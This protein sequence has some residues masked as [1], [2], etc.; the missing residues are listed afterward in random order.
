MSKRT[1]LHVV[2]PLMTALLSAGVV[3]A[4]SAA[5][6]PGSAAA[7]TPT[8]AGVH[9]APSLPSSADVVRGRF[10]APVALD[11]GVL[12][13]APAPAGDRPLVSSAKAGRKIWASPVL[14]SRQRGPL[15]YGLV[16]IS[17][18][19][20]GVPRVT[21][22]LA[23]VGFARSS[24]MANC[25]NEAPGS[26]ATPGLSGTA[27]ASD[28]YGAVVIGAAHG[29]PAVAYT[30]PSVLCGSVQPASLTQASEVVSVPWRAVTGV[31]NESIRIRVSMP[32][33][34]SLEGF[35]SGGSA[36]VSTIT[37]NAIVPD[38]HG[39]CAGASDIDETVP[40][41]PA[42]NPPGAP[43]PLVSASTIIRHGRLGPAVTTV[44][45]S[46]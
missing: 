22:L 44:A 46:S 32:A 39:P 37:V 26:T 4:L 6:S 16:T 31:V 42:G 28:G 18:R 9:R 40:L 13:V 17:L 5:S 8:L 23:W 35:S 29:A 15:G 11:G 21:K 3:T 41:G 7:A 10:V 30:A 2:V 19:A 38:V 45:P 14:Q 33:C 27:L 34:G 20:N 36:K 43:P 1:G 24:E 25:P 12:T